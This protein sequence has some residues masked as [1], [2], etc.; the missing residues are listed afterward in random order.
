MIRLCDFC[1]LCGEKFKA[2][3]NFYNFLS[4]NKFQ[5][6]VIASLGHLNIELGDLE[7]GDYEPPLVPAMADWVFLDEYGPSPMELAR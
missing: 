5:A 3:K 4:K 2:T 6:E 1:V 7:F